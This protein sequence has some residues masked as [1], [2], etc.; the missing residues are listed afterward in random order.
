M[1][2]SLAMDYLRAEKC[3]LYRSA[4]STAELRRMSLVSY[5]WIDRDDIFLVRK[6]V[7]A[8]FDRIVSS[9]GPCL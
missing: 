4:G 2:A 8:P 1:G 3:L 6:E 5:I 7:N 9:D